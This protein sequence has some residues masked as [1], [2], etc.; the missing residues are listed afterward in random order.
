MRALKIAVSAAMIGLVVDGAG[1]SQYDFD[2]KN[3]NDMRKAYLICKL[4]NYQDGD[5]PDVWEKCH[6]Y[7]LIDW[8]GDSKCRKPPRF[9]DKNDDAQKALRDGNDMASDGTVDDDGN[10]PDYTEASEEAYALEEST[11]MESDDPCASAADQ[12][13]CNE[14]L[15]ADAEGVEAYET[16]TGSISDDETEAVQ[17]AQESGQSAVATVVSTETTAA[18]TEDDLIVDDSYLDETGSYAG[19]S[20]YEAE[21]G[22]PSLDEEASDTETGSSEQ[23]A[24]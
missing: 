10:A 6:L 9:T 8:D 7:P 12:S 4:S 19:Y 15:D 24:P 20:D 17:L 18:V 13:A 14:A 22:L 16:N 3:V 5:C 21:Y 1:A 11:S 2:Y 23:V